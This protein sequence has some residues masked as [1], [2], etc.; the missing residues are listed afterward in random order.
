VALGRPAQLGV[1]FLAATKSKIT[2]RVH[3]FSLFFF[4]LSCVSLFLKKRAVDRMNAGFCL[5]IK[6]RLFG[7]ITGVV[8]QITG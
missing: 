2:S 4:F 8:G 1:F 7:Q 6:L 3:A 5:W